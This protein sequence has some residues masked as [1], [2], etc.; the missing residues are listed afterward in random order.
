MLFALFFLMLGSCAV[1]RQYNYPTLPYKVESSSETGR[2]YTHFQLL[3]FE[4]RYNDFNFYFQSIFPFRYEN[5]SILISIQ[6]WSY[7]SKDFNN[8]EDTMLHMY[9]DECRIILPSGSAID[10]LDNIS[11]VDYTYTGRDYKMKAPPKIL[12][13]VQ[14]QYMD[15]GRKILYL[16]SIE[17]DNYGVF[18]ELNAKIPSSVQTLRMEFT[19]TVVWENQG[20]VKTRYNM[21]FKKKTF[22]TYPY[23]V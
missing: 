9:I 6:N 11:K 12:R 20:E 19:L 3:M 4:E 10:L 15:D 8:D 21:R 13:N 7:L 1:L 18:I 14:P 16:D 23:T 22:I 17:E 2:L 5:Y